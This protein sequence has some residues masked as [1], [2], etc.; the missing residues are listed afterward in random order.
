LDCETL[1]HDGTS[2]LKIDS[3]IDCNSTDYKKFQLVASCFVVLYQSIPPLWWIL[4]WCKRSRLNPPTGGDDRLA[5]FV[6]DRDSDLSKLRFLFGT[7]SPK[8]YYFECIEMYRR[9]FFIGILPLVSSNSLR[10][11]SL[12]F[13]VALGWFLLFR[14]VGPFSRRSTN[15]VA[16]V[17]QLSIMLTYGAALAIEAQ[18][19][20]GVPPLVFGTMLV[21]L[22]IRPPATSMISSLEQS[23]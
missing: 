21:S 7:Y 13:V 15:L 12:G 2:F 9:I 20:R 3:S 18:L 14:E 19:S 22:P 5:Q 1:P 6:R 8:F 16:Y 10:R 4:L 17:A 11:A 23:R